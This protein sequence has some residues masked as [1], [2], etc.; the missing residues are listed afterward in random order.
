MVP[1]WLPPPL[2]LAGTSIEDDY[3]SL[4]EVFES[5]FINSSCPIV[6]GCKVVACNLLDPS[7]M[8]GIY[9]YGFTHL[10]THGDK[11]RLI[12]YDRAKKLPWVRAVLDN[13][14][15]PEVTAFYVEQ[16]KGLTMYLWLTDNDFVVTLRALKSKKEQSSSPRKIIVTAY[17]VY[18]YGRK[19]LQ[20]LYGRSVR[21]L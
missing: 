21:Q 20:R 2:R 15:A 16:P 17:H 19:D 18:T 9:T 11:E 6:D 14:T 3:R 8:G 5:D 12:D 7:V 10:I 13:Y 4:Y 1:E